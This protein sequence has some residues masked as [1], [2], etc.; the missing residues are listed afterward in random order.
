MITKDLIK[1][2][3]CDLDVELQIFTKA[4]ISSNRSVRPIFFAHDLSLD[5]RKS[6]WFLPFIYFIIS[7]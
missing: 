6:G 4:E 1:V 3:V 2:I 7:F 5:R